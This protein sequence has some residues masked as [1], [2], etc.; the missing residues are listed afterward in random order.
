MKMN[1]QNPTCP[2]CFG[3]VE[4]GT[5]VTPGADL[6]I[7]CRRCG[8]YDVSPGLVFDSTIAA[9]LRPYLSAATRQANDEGRVLLL[10][11]KELQDIA[12]PHIS[13]TVSRK[14][15]KVL[16]LVASRCK[17][18]GIVVP[19][20]FDLD[21]PIVDCCDR[22]ELS[23][24]LSFLQE[25]GLLRGYS[26]EGSESVDGYAPTLEGWQTIEPTLRP[27]GIPGRCFVA[28]CFSEQT[29]EAYTIGIEPA[30]LDAGFKPIRIDRKEHNNE[31]PDEIIAE[32]RN[33]QFMVADFTGQRAGVYYEA[34]FAMGLGRP[35]IWCCR[36][37]EIS[38]LHFDT[39]HKNHI[40]WATPEEL[41]ERLY[42]RIRATILEQA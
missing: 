28:M 12:A 21:P 7:V 15:E 24:Y 3:A 11:R 16:R 17:R 34:G 31:I 37:D 6:N 20:D 36:K 8:R 27:G 14:V 26:D 22:H 13:V 10:R 30:V 1:L 23:W 35:V 42:R 40:D 4:V 41:H 2:L 19:V 32:I 9:D 5:P 38:K 33:C 25:K 18:P 39:N 29:R